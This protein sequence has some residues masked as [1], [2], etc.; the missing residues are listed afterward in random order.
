ML[1]NY[2]QPLFMSR[3]FSTKLMRYLTNMLAQLADYYEIH[4]FICITSKSCL[5]LLLLIIVVYPGNLSTPVFSVSLCNHR[6]FFG[7]RSHIQ[8][9]QNYFLHLIVYLFIVC[10][11]CSKAH[12]NLILFCL[13]ERFLLKCQISIFF[14]YI[15]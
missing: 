9:M 8:R 1:K 6:N 10:Y 15:S 14:I 4:E 3:I 5:V 13:Y 11:V 12:C 7:D 2:S